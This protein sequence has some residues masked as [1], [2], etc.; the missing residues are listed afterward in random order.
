M[1]YFNSFPN[2]IYQFGE[3]TST[4]IFNNIAIYADVVDQIKDQVTAYRNY[5]IQPYERPDQVSFK[6][7]NTPNFH[8]TFFLMNDNLRETGWPISNDDVFQIV[9]K[10]H[11]HKTINTNSVLWDKFKEGQTFIG[12]QSGATGLVH[13][14]ILDLGQ[15]IVTNINGNFIA[16][17]TLISYDGNGIEQIILNSLIDEYNSI[18]HYVDADGEYVDI[19]PTNNVQTYTPVTYLEKYIKQNEDQKTI[20]VIRKDIILDIAIAFKEAIQS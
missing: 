14:Q 19:D 8:W 16:G 12:Q 11:P 2:A 18:H 13:K 15:L 6:L 5:Q 1:N 10:R 4:T 9:K 3:E 7:Y 17:E 20:R